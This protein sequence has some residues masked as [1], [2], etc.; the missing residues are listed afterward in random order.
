MFKRLLILLIL[1]PSLAQAQVLFKNLPANSSSPAYPADADRAVDETGTVTQTITWNAAAQYILGKLNGSC[2]VNTTNFTITC[3]GTAA[4]TFDQLGTG[5]NGQMTGTC[6]TGCE[7]TVSGT[8][9][10]NANVINDQAVP[11]DCSSL[12]TN[13]SSQ[14]GCYTAAPTTITLGASPMWVRVG[15]SLGCSTFSTAG[16]TNSVTLFTLPA[17]GVVHGIKIR[18]TTAF[19]GTSISAYTLSVGISGNN[20]KLAP[21]YSVF[22]A[23]SGT[24]I[25]LT[26]DFDEENDSSPTAITVTAVSTGANLSACSTG[27][28]DI[29]AL[30]SLGL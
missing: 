15:V 7:L 18:D 6:S 14:F 1:L 13:V 17:G 5:A 16:T 24:T 28:A 10:I 4:T 11:A 21:A 20:T 2:S 29:W 22:Q 27:A 23:P 26:S 9:T 19:S 3:T 12:Y 30:L 25:Q 8:G